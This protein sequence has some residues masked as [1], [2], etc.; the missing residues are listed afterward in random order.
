MG[1][2]HVV[3]V[4]VLTALVVVP[5]VMAIIRAES[6]NEFKVPNLFKTGILTSAAFIY[7]FAVT[8]AFGQRLAEVDYCTAP[9]RQQPTR[10]RP[11]E[12]D[13]SGHVAVM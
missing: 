11:F 12:P 9:L 10:A 7:L 1:V 4:L 2:I 5:W 6:T 13:T 8:P 3:V